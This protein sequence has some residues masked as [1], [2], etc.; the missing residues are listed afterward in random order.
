M[1]GFT[2]PEGPGSFDEFLVRFLGGGDRLLEETRGRLHALDITVE[3]T[4]AAVDWLAERGHQPEFGARPMRRTIQ[5]EVDN[6]LSA[7]LLDGKLAAGQHVTVDVADGAL[8]FTVTE[9]PAAVG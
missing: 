2:G 5:R 4:L 7:L 9:Q 6:R 1:T 8:G 3:F